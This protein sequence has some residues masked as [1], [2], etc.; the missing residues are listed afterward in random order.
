M[1][2][3]TGGHSSSRRL[4]RTLHYCGHRLN[5]TPRG[6]DLLHSRGVCRRTDC[7]GSGM[8][9]V[10]LL[11]FATLDC[12]CVVGRYQD[13]HA[14]RE[15]AYV[16]EKGPVCAAHLHR[17]NHTIAIAPAPRRFPSALEARAS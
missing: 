11:G 3:K 8:S 1:I 2:G 4:A 5:A 10:R 6:S 13:V 9:V 12:G 16:E 7:E 17:R 15:V 14:N